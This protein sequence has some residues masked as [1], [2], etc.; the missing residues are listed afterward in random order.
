MLNLW[1]LIN[2]FYQNLTLVQ[3]TMK[4]TK[5]YGIN[6]PLPHSACWGAKI[7]FLEVKGYPKYHVAKVRVCSEKGFGKKKVFLCPLKAFADRSVIPLPWFLIAIFLQWLLIISSWLLFMSYSVVTNSTTLFYSLPTWQVLQ[8]LV[9][10]NLSINF[11]S[12]WWIGRWV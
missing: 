6:F 12:L 5:A 2:H 11:F 9:S 8:F 1:R 10:S 4:T 7:L 3:S